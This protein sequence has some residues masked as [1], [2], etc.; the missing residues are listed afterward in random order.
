MGVQCIV[1]LSTFLGAMKGTCYRKQLA[2]YWYKY[3]RF[4]SD[5]SGTIGLSSFSAA[6]VAVQQLLALPAHCSNKE[7]GPSWVG[8]IV[9]MF[10]PEK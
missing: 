5:S 1:L 8:V 9:A 10:V 3:L 6:L 4:L 2:I 7:M